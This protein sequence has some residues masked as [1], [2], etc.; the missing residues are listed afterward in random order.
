M[1]NAKEIS[2]IFTPEG[3][4]KLQTGQILIFDKD[5]RKI[6]LKITKILKKNKRKPRVWAR[7]VTTYAPEEIAINDKT[8]I[9]KEDDVSSSDH[10]N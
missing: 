3:A 8:I 2:D 5:G 7:E 4:A 10:N 9:Q 6:E 1:N